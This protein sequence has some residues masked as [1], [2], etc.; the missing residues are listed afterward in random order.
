MILLPLDAIVMLIKLLSIF[1]LGGMIGAILAIPVVGYL[2]MQV[3]KN[4]ALCTLLI[5]IGMNLVQ[6]GKAHIE[7]FNK[8]IETAK[9]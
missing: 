9:A 6:A 7:S 1:G 5:E 2:G 4:A 8:L 3:Y